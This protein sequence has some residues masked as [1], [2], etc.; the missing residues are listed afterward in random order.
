MITLE[1]K[2]T[3]CV[4]FD[5]GEIPFTI[6]GFQKEKEFLL[7]VCEGASMKFGWEILQYN[8]MKN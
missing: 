6:D 1:C 7:E 2:G 8:P 4:G 3:N 5:L